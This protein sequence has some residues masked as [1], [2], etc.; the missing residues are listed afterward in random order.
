LRQSVVVPGEGGGVVGAVAVGRL[1][2]GLARRARCADRRW[3]LDGV[4]TAEEVALDSQHRADPAVRRRRGE[5]DAEIELPGELADR[6]EA[7]TGRIAETGEEDRL[8]AG[9]RPLGVGPFVLGHAHTRV[10]D[11][12]AD[13]VMD[14]LQVDHDV[15]VGRGVT[16]RVVEELGDD[17][18]DR[19]DG[20]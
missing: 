6:G 4:D 10:V 17:D 19:L 8:G 18:G 15:G 13:A 5:V 3:L 9:H 20:V 11:G 14:V 7:H 1:R 12:D 16:Q 2:R